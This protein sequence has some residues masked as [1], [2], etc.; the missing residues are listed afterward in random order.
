M[1]TV[2]GM[3]GESGH[4]VRQYPLLVT[5]E[6][7]VVGSIATPV[8]PS[9]TGTVAVTAF[10]VKSI[11]ETVFALALATTAWFLPG[12]IATA[13][14]YLPTGIVPTMVFVPMSINTT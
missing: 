1:E 6:L 5:T 3:P 9:P 7:F 2:A 4:P 11:M 8:G 14:G 10:V 12:L 13:R